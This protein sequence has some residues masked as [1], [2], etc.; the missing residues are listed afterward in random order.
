MWPS[1]GGLRGVYRPRPTEAAKVFERGEPD[2]GGATP[3]QL[4]PNPKY[5]SGGAGSAVL[6]SGL[7]VSDSVELGA[8]SLLLALILAKGWVLVK[9]ISQAG[10]CK[11][12]SRSQRTCSMMKDSDL[13]STEPRLTVGYVKILL[14]T[15]VEEKAGDTDMGSVGFSCDR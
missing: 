8:Q 14:A 13:C 5:P 3:L 4:I 15:G 11:A 6:R 12:L 9:L 7:R 1:K 2:A 10:C